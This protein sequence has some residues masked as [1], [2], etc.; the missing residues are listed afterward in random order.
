MVGKIWT[1][2]NGFQDPSRSVHAILGYQKELAR[3][4]Q[5]EMESFYKTYRNIYSFNHN[6]LT[7]LR[8]NGYNEENKPIFSETKGIFNRGDGHSLGFELLLRK[9]VGA[10]SGWMGYSFSQ[11]R[12]RIDGINEE[13]DFSPR[14]DRTSTVNLVSN[15]DVR[16]ALWKLRGR[17]GTF[18][19]GRSRWKLGMNW[20]IRPASPSPSRV[21]GT[22]P[23]R[24]RGRPIGTWSTLRPESTTSAFRPTRDWM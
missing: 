21:R 16:L 9:D 8:S 6:F 13:E 1:T 3:N 4:Y 19:Q 12:Y 24:H 17:R 10:V 14:H 7:E 18:R 5:F 15:V 23:L 11:T 20:S 2:S 22:S